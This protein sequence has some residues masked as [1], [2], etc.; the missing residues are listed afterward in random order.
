ME[1][2]RKRATSLETRA[3]FRDMC[4]DFA[5]K[6]HRKRA[7]KNSRGSKF[8]EAK[9]KLCYSRASRPISSGSLFHKNLYDFGVGTVPYD[10]VPESTAHREARAVRAAPAAT[11]KVLFQIPLST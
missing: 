8:C 9:R 4:D 11:A 7:A 6:C 2:G 3:L 5:A 10:Y 1:F